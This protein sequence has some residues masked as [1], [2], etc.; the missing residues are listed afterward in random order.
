VGKLNFQ[1]P[2]PPQAPGPQAANPATQPQPQL[3]GLQALA[4]SCRPCH[5]GPRAA[6]G[7]VTGGG[8]F[9]RFRRCNCRTSCFAVGTVGTVGTPHKQRL[10]VSPLNGRQWGQ[11]GQN[12]GYPHWKRSY[13]QISAACM[14]LQGHRAPC[15]TGT[16]FKFKEVQQAS[17]SDRAPAGAPLQVSGGTLQAPGSGLALFLPGTSSPHRVLQREGS[18]RPPP[19][20]GRSTQAQAPPLLHR[21]GLH[22]SRANMS[23]VIR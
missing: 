9:S 15:K 13:P 8:T 2:S 20:R 19:F 12:R 5:S 1:T 11:W 22:T 14:G 18:S 7:V 3:Q 23:G 16:T 21:V 17:T 6:Q 10:C 4:R